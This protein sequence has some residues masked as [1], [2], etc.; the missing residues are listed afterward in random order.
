M[1]VTKSG[2]YFYDFE[3]KKDPP[4]ILRES[5]NIERIASYDLAIADGKIYIVIGGKDKTVV[6]IFTSDKDGDI[7][8][9]EKREIYHHNFTMTSVGMNVFN[10]FGVNKSWLALGG[11]AGSLHIC[12]N[13]LEL[14]TRYDRTLELNAVDFSE[15][16]PHKSTISTIAF[17][18][19]FHQMATASLDGSI[20]LWNLSLLDD[21]SQHIRLK[22]TGAGIWD[23]CYINAD[24]II[25]AENINTAIWRTNI[26]AQR[27]E[28]ERLCQNREDCAFS[29]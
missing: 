27:R 24:E 29:N 12:D 4:N 19:S 20:Q 11:E 25:I 16:R 14:F 23:L 7:N 21:P 15:F 5:Y 28:L 8:L 22:N 10:Q 18:D 6:L 1:A 26:N 3:K 2:L 13:F 17:N 9:F